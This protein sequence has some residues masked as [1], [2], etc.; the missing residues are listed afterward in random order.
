MALRL[1]YRSIA[2]ALF[3]CASAHAAAATHAGRGVFNFTSGSGCPLGDAT[4][5]GQA[6][7]RLALA[8]ADTHATVDTEGHTIH[9]DNTRHYDADTPVGDVL[10]Q[11]T[12]VDAKGKRVPLS[13]HLKLNRDGNKWKVSMHAHAPVR[14]DFSDVRI[15]PYTVTVNGPKG[16]EIVLTQERAIAVLAK[17]SLSARIAQGLV[18]VRPAG[19]LADAPDV[20]V[21]LGVGKVAK[22]LA[23]VRFQSQLDGDAGIA[24]R[25]AQGNWSLDMEALSGQI[26]RRAVQGDLFLFGLENETLLQ[27]LREKGFAK[28]DAL[29]IGAKDGQGYLRFN[30]V[31][32]AFAQADRVARLFMEDSFLGLILTQQRGAVVAAAVK[33]GNGN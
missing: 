8:D 25:I 12:G 15:D 7:D 27:P 19:D 28:H 32:Q 17:P 29:T 30:G 11:G 6:C 9:F 10:L 23:R 13:L 4:A 21:S 31:Q 22:R 14:G 20:I 16:E 18:H 1:T 24:A 2:A 3:L 26:P 33:T 5:G